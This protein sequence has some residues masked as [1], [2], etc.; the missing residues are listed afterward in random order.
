MLAA[1]P[2]AGDVGRGDRTDIAKW[3]GGRYTKEEFQAR[4]AWCRRSSN[5]SLSPA[6]HMLHHDQPEELARRLQIFLAG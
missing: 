6:G 2:G 3:W 5:T 1:H 4:L